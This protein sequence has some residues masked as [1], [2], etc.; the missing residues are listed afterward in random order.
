MAIK[1]LMTDIF[2]YKRRDYLCVLQCQLTSC[3]YYAFH[4]AMAREITQI[5]AKMNSNA[6]VT[7]LEIVHCKI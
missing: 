6:I 3:N 1:R 7:N 2:L 4:T 5:T